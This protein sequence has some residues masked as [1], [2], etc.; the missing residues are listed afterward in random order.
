MSLILGNRALYSVLLSISL[1]PF[2]TSFSVS[3]CIFYL[4]ISH[5]R[6]LM[7]RTNQ[8]VAV[9][10]LLY[11]LPLSVDHGIH[12][13]ISYPPLWRYE[14][15]AAALNRGSRNNYLYF[16][17]EEAAGPV[18]SA[19]G[20]LISLRGKCCWLAFF[21]QQQ[22][23][24]C[25]KQIWMEAFFRYSLS[26]CLQPNSKNNRYCVTGGF[27]CGLADQHYGEQNGGLRTRRGIK[28]ACVLLEFQSDLEI[29]VWA[30][31]YILYLCL[32]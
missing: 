23:C 17:D 15:E 9:R 18:A 20:F 31:M 10:G 26:L 4:F 11:S 21:S 27:R 24:P 7:R 2:L 19:L 3:V 6:C 1:S 29:C 13:T 28:K 22:P 12:A 8:H 30:W 16:I 25:Y 5:I 14:N 32:T